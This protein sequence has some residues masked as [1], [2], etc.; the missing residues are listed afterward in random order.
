M[1]ISHTGRFLMR[2]VVRDMNKR[3]GIGLLA[4]AC[5]G[6]IG[7]GALIDAIGGVTVRTNIASDAVALTVFDPLLPGTQVRPTWTVVAGSVNRDVEIVLV[8]T[9]KDYPLVRTKLLFGNTRATLP[10]DLI[11]GNARLELI[12][13][14]DREVI[15][16]VAVDILPAG[17]DCVR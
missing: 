2:W 15:S 8:T 6:L 13:Q 7:V 17:P 4:A 14:Q 10:C 5:V 16:S 3:V 9:S 1:R 12:G 11:A